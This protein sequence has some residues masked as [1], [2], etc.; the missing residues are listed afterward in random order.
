MYFKVKNFPRVKKFSDKS[1]T[2]SSTPPAQSTWAG[3]VEKF[4][5]FNYDMYHWQKWFESYQRNDKKK[6]PPLRGSEMRKTVNLDGFGKCSVCQWGYYQKSQISTFSW[7]MTQWIW[8]IMVI[9]QVLERASGHAGKVGKQWQRRAAGE[10][11][12]IYFQIVAEDRVKRLFTPID[13]SLPLLTQIYPRWRLFTPTDAS[14]PLLTFVC[15]YWR[16]FIPAN[17]CLN[18]LTFVFPL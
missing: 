17:A 6:P 13:A 1:D 4:F 8:V 11:K 5:K 2:R 18:L 3:G 9:F 7:G 16:L 12:F 10:K 14:L 15:L